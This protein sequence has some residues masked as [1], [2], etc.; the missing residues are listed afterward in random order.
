MSHFSVLVIGPNVDE[1][2]APYHEFECTGLD[3]EFVQDV[4]VTERYHKDYMDRKAQMLRGPDGQLHSFFTPEGNWDPRF[5]TP[6]PSDNKWDKGR[7]QKFVPAGY[8]EVEVPEHTVKTFAEFAKGWGGQEVIPFGHRIDKAGKHKYGYIQL[9][10]SGSVLKIIDRTNPNKKWDWYQV[11]GRWSGYFR[12]KPE[13]MH[14]AKANLGEPGTFGRGREDIAGYTDRAK[15]GHVDF[16]YMR[17]ENGAEAAKEWERSRAIL[18]DIPAKWKPWPTQKWFEE[19]KDEYDIEELRDSYSA[20]PAIRAFKNDK[21]FNRDYAWGGFD[22]FLMTR[23][24]YVRRARNRTIVP[25]AIVYKGEWIGRGRMGWWGTS[26]DEIDEDLW[27][28][29]ANKYIDELPDSTMLTIV[30]CHI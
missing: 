4:D 17:N 29:Q 24:A 15:K 10:E 16:E 25:Y 14:H 30:D 26:L 19:N 23:E 6:A 2:L 3:N 8:T 20:Q 21:D 12:L 18:G 28:E 1:Q 27:I 13:Q 22:R 5:S 7:R 11:G 9:G